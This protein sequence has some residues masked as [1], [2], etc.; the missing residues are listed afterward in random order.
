MTLQANAKGLGEFKEDVGIQRVAGE[1]SAKIAFNIRLIM[2]VL[3]TTTADDLILSFNNELSP[4]KMTIENDD[5]FC[6]IIMP[7]RT[8]DYQD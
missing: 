8:T 4:C 5:S 7:I 2:D 6:Y 1:Q 3:K